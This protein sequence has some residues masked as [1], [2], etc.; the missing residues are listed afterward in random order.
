MRAGEKER[1]IF[2]REIRRA[3]GTDPRLPR[4][5][6]AQVTA[7]FAEREML[8]LPV[9]TEGATAVLEL[10]SMPFLFDFSEFDG[11]DAWE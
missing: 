1:E 2:R 10:G 8:A 7:A 3:M 6:S 5:M 4:E 9:E 11:P